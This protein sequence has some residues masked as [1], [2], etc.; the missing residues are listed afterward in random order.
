MP[1]FELT[2]G[3]K[4]VHTKRSTTSTVETLFTDP[5]DGRRAEKVR[6]H[7]KIESSSGDIEVRVKESTSNDGVTWSTPSTITGYATYVSTDGW[8]HGTTFASLSN[9]RFLR[10]A[11]ESRNKTGS[12][13]DCA[14]VTLSAEITVTG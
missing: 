13:T 10:F 14:L 3:P 6:L 5:I 11:I 2:E 4:P 12:G 9:A 8:N 1:A 7:L